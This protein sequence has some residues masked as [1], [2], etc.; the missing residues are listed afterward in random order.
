MVRRALRGN[1]RR[2]QVSVGRSLPAPIGGWDAQ[3]PIAA[4]P[5]QNAFQLDNWVPRP[6]FVELR[7]GYVQQ[8][9]G[10]PAAVESMMSFRGAAGS[11]KLFAAS[12][13]ALYDVSTSPSAWPAALVSG[14]TNNR[15]NYTA[16]AN[17]AGA[18]LIACNGGDAP[19]GY[20]A[21]AWAALPVLTSVGVPVIAPASL[22]NVFAHKGRLFF[23]QQ[24]TL[25]AW[26]PAAGAVGGACTV[27]DLSNVF[28]KGGRLICAANW[29][30]VLGL[31]PDDYAVFMT[32]QGQ[33]AVYQGTDPTNAATWSLIGVYD[34]GRPL[35][36][37]ALLKYGGDLAVITSDGVVP[38]STAIK[39]DR[40]Q[41]NE[42]ALTAKI[43]NAF[44]AAVKAYS[45]NYGWQGILY[46]GTSTSADDNASGGSL[47]IV[48]V[49]LSTLGTSMQ[50]VQNVLTGAW[51]RF[52]AI[53]S[54]CWELANGAI[55][56]GSTDGV[57]QWDQGA[58]DNGLAIVG[59]VCGAFT[60]FGD[61]AR[62]KR[63]TAIRPL[64]NAPAIVQPALEVD[65]DYIVTE[66]TAIATV[67]TSGADAA[68]RYDW[69]GA[70][71]VGYVGAA[72]MKLNLSGDPDSPLLAWNSVGADDDLLSVD[73]A[74][75]IDLLTEV[76]LP[77]DVPCQLL[78]FDLIYEVGGQL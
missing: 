74:D 29:S 46:P 10:S 27:L 14:F 26:I 40:S 35:G 63:F 7:R 54:F 71:G 25:Y 62:Q 56:F 15:W 58:S 47:A 8:V 19:I 57:Y 59:D 37:K 2:R 61:G 66:P 28:S 31:T 55:Y 73:S 6:G 65:V 24:G 45:A 9:T 11:D 69:T 12:N 64:L 32:D 75:T 39:L 34:L 60:N 41:Q 38:L 22:F 43:M 18:W 36:P 77:L 53:D 48:N 68:I 76:A 13:G 21:G 30:A 17:T 70:T 42:V 67:T 3:N 5:L 50:F 20:N 16:F 1:P 23:L 49:P 72:R 44:A 52:L 33:V 78:G 4:M 51:C